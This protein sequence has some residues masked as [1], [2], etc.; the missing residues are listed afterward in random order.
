MIES[1]LI[2]TSVLLH[3]PRAAEGALFIDRPSANA[4]LLIP[5]YVLEELDHLKEEHSDR[6]QRAREVCRRLDQMRRSNQLGHGQLS[7]RGREVSIVRCQNESIPERF[8]R[9]GGLTF[10]W[11]ILQ[12]AL[13]HSAPLITL[14]LNLKLRA[15]NQGVTTVEWL[16]D[17]EQSFSHQPSVPPA[18]S[19]IPLIP[20]RDEVWGIKAL[21]DEQAIALNALLN[22]EISLVTLTGKAGTGKTLLA[23]A[24][25]LEQVTTHRHYHR[26]LVSRAIFPLGKDIGYLPGTLEEKMEP[27]LQP[28]YD[29]LDFLLETRTPRQ[30]NRQRPRAEELIDL[31]LIDI[32]PITYIR[33]RSISSQFLIVDEAQNLTPHEMKTMLT[34]AG[35]GTKV[36][37]IGDPYQVDHPYLDAERNGL[38]YVAERF[39]GQTC[40]A[41]IQLLSGERSPLAELAADLL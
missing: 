11:L 27:W 24:A 19:H 35:R 6:G 9:H 21:N 18:T 33:G 32:A 36:V 28:I 1:Y 25:G 22:P 12:C 38:I 2:D 30:P 13:E 10:D 4:R 40:A 16:S 39:K 8:T 5:L 20:H 15:D 7:S 14:D 37:L 3:D 29:N 17:E 31:G 23:L 26:V 34:R 41:Q